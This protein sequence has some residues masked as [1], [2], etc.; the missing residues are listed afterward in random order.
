MDGLE[1][2]Q[3]WLAELGARE[4]VKKG[5]EYNKKPIEEL[6]AEAGAIRTRV[7]ETT[8]DKASSDDEKPKQ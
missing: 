1:H 2:V 6:L 8:L 4:G 7:G 3:R 5:L